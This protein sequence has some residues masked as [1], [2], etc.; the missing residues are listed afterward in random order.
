LSRRKPRVSEL[1]QVGHALAAAANARLAAEAGLRESDARFRALF[2][3]VPVAVAVFDPRTLDFVA[4][5]DRACAK[6]GYSR[7]EFAAL[8]VSDIEAGQTEDE[9]RRWAS[10]LDAAGSPQEFTTRH[11]T[12]SG[13]IRDVLAR[14]ARVLLDGCALAYVAWIDITEQRAQARALH[15]LMQCQTAILEALPAHVALLDAQGV[16]VTVNAAWRA[17]RLPAASRIAGRVPARTTSPP[18]GPPPRPATRP[19]WPRWTGCAT[20]WSAGAS[21]SN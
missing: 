9:V 20:S 19:H 10:S 15:Q 13:E 5:N 11:R 21:A 8:R 4:F 3:A 16:I 1:A 12:R 6:L 18:A 17:L 14:V 2:D 7:V